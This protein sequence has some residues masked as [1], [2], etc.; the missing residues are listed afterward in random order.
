MS[1]H[2]INNMFDDEIVEEIPVQIDYKRRLRGMTGEFGLVNVTINYCDVT[3]V[4]SDIV[5]KIVNSS[6]KEYHI[7]LWKN[8]EQSF[9]SDCDCPDFFFRGHICKHIYWLGYNYFGS[10]DPYIWDVQRFSRFIT[11][12]WVRQTEQ[13][14]IRRNPQC[15]ICLED[16]YYDVAMTIC[17]SHLGG[18]GNSVHSHCW[19]RFYDVTGKPI[20]IMCRANLIPVI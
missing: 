13:D 3:N 12:H 11:Q 16:I 9:G 5:C 2:T 15:P 20:C 19:K 10:I 8:L 1:V 6:G 18:C 7:T 14:A 4:V 17:C